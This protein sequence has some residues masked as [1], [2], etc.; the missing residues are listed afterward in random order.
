MLMKWLGRQ[1]SR[2]LGPKYMHSSSKRY[3]C[4]GTD[5]MVEGGSP[6]ADLCGYRTGWL[7]VSH[8]VPRLTAD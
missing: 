8:V 5:G 1:R 6:H 7:L 4:P 2:E 3:L